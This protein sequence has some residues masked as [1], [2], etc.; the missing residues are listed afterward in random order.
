[1]T[2]TINVGYNT[3]FKTGDKQFAGVT[4]DDLSLTAQKKSSITKTDQGQRKT[5]IVGY[6][7]T[8]KVT[9]LCCTSDDASLI[10]REAALDLFLAKEEIDIIYLSGTIP[11]TGKAVCVGYSE[12]TSADPA[13][14]PTFGLDFELIGELTKSTPIP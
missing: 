14:D 9:G 5:K 6:D 10:D 4:Q 7:G 8:F 2:E 3:L 13:N 11:Y 12:S 1:M